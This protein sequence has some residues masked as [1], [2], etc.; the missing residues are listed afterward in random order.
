MRK[1]TDSPSISS[2]VALIIKAALRRR[3]C[4]A[5]SWHRTPQQIR[6]GN[7]LLLL[8]PLLITLA[9]CYSFVLMQS[10]AK[11]S[12]PPVAAAEKTA[13]SDNLP[14]VT[15]APH[16]TLP[17]L[18]DVVEVSNSPASTMSGPVAQ[19]STSSVMSLQAAS[20]NA[21]NLMIN[22]THSYQPKSS[23]KRAG[24]PSPKPLLFNAVQTKLR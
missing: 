18:S 19:P 20:N 15:F 12:H 5:Y 6:G 22:L 21:D 13:A 4:L 1:L 14:A 16:S 10:H 11:P 24:A 2:I 7:G 17:T 9:F 23:S 8:P 3:Y